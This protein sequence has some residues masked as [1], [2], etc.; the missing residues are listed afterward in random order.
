MRYADCIGYRGKPDGIHQRT[1]IADFVVK[2]LSVKDFYNCVNC[3]RLV[4]LYLKI[5][6]HY[7]TFLTVS[8]LYAAKICSKFVATLSFA[9][10]LSR[11]TK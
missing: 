6:L 1:D 5:K 2:A 9:I 7:S 10:E 8:G 11:I 3:V 4:L